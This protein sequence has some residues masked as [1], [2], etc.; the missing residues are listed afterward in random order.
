MTHQ[1]QQDRSVIPNS[2]TPSKTEP[3]HHPSAETRLLPAQHSKRHVHA[4]LW[5]ATPRRAALE[6]LGFVVLGMLVLL[7]VLVFNTTQGF[8]GGSANH[9]LAV[10]LGC[11][12]LGEGAAL[13]LALRLRLPHGQALQQASQEALVGC[14]YALVMGVAYAFVLVA[15]VWNGGTLLLAG[16]LDAIVFAGAFGIGLPLLHGVS[17]GVFRAILVFLR[18]WN[19]LRQRRLL[20]ALT[21]DQLMIVLV[22]MVVFGIGAALIVVVTDFLNGTA[23]GPLVDQLFGLSVV[24][25]FYVALIVVMLIGTL[26]LA[27]VLSFVLVR[28]IVRRVEQ[29]ADATEALRRGDYTARVHVVGQDEIAQLQTDFN[30]MA[31]DLNGTLRA[32]Q[33]E[34]DRVTALLQAQRE[35]TASVSHELRTPVATQRSYLD[36]LLGEGTLPPHV[37][38]E[39]AVVERETRRLQSLIDDLFVL[40]RTEIG[41]LTLRMEPLDLGAVAERVAATLAPIG[42][43]QGRVTIAAQTPPTPVLALADEERFEQVLRNLVHN[44]VR[45]TPPGG[46]VAIAVTEDVHHAIVQV[47]DTGSGI[48]PDDLPHIWKRFYRADAARSLDQSGAGLGLALVKELT[49]AMGGSVAVESA[50]GEGS[51]FILRLPRAEATQ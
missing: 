44:G 1:Y 14:L 19:G 39:L 30:A 6:V 27:I 47:N 18:R 5:S 15:D 32:L 3:S 7:G 49:E 35:L 23:R 28:R 33:D 2:H 48:A 9:E 45:H 12:A 46:I 51:S 31:S 25:G 26:P 20:W 17:Y 50:V 34:R 37:R 38:T 21:H 22:L 4:L 16:G 13:L 11:I 8:S 10:L 36:T 42:W 24:G 41:R 43:Q 40:S 29:L